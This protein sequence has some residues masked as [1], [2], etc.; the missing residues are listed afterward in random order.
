MINDM[1]VQN[2]LSVRNNKFEQIQKFKY[3]E[4]HILNIVKIT[5]MEKLTLE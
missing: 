4:S 2:N 1:E 5:C 3:L